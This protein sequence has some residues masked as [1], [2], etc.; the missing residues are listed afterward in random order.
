MRTE[1]HSSPTII[2]KSVLRLLLFYLPGIHDSLGSLADG[3]AGVDGGAKHVAFKGKVEFGM[4]QKHRG[5]GDTE[6]RFKERNIPVAR[7]Q[8]E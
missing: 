7:W 3:G 1:S 8:R 4:R 5:R 6:R 2:P